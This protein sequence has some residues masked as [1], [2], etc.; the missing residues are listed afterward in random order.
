MFQLE[1]GEALRPWTPPLTSAPTPRARD[2]VAAIDGEDTDANNANGERDVAGTFNQPRSMRREHDLVVQ[3]SAQLRGISLVAF[4]SAKV[5]GAMR[6]AIANALLAS[7][8]DDDRVALAH[9]TELEGGTGG[10]EFRASVV[11]AANSQR[12]AVLERLHQ[13]VDF[14]QPLVGSFVSGLEE[15]NALPLAT[16]RRIRLALVLPGRAFPVSTAAPTVPPTAPLRNLPQCSVDTATPAIAC[17][18][19]MAT[20]HMGVCD[21]AERCQCRAPF[22]LSTNDGRCWKASDLHFNVADLISGLLS[23]GATQG[24]ADDDDD[25]QPREPSVAAD[26]GCVAGLLAWA[27]KHGAFLARTTMYS[28]PL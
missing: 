10:V 21:A 28:R 7:A 1:T 20:P 19:D 13:A 5:Q 23:P 17:S 8:G 26:D 22:Q 24:G 4:R 25:G 12:A 27:S 15:E 6:V 18:G 11:L 14:T 9:A 2:N 3:F 16:L